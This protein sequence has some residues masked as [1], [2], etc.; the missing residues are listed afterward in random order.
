M[1]PIVRVQQPINML[2][3][4]LLRNKKNRLKIHLLFKRKAHPPRRTLTLALSLE[5]SCPIDF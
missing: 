1:P 2:A 5:P 4:G 3:Y